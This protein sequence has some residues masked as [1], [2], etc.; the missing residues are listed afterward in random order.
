VKIPKKALVVSR[1]SEDLHIKGTAE[2]AMCGLP[3]LANIPRNAVDP[4]LSLCLECLTAVEDRRNGR[5]EM[6]LV[7]S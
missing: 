1:D 3:V 5:R 2:T 4:A 7:A 6:A